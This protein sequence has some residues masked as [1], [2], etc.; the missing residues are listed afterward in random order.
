MVFSWFL[1]IFQI[2]SVFRWYCRSMKNFTENF[3]FIGYLHT[4][5]S[6]HRANIH[7]EVSYQIFFLIFV[8]S[9]KALNK[10]LTVS[11]LTK[12]LVH[13]TNHQTRILKLL[14]HKTDSF[15]C[16]QLSFTILQNLV[17]KIIPYFLHHCPHTLSTNSPW[18][19]DFLPNF[20]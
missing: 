14:K 18:R 8:C 1:H 5:E 2:F 11:S 9:I 3:L 13:F 19:E 4:R 16:R 7:L 20:W 17:L 12:S 10:N 15:L 6:I